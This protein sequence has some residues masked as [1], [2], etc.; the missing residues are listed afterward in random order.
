MGTKSNHLLVL[1]V[2]TGRIVEIT[3]P[4]APPRPPTPS[5]TESCGIHCMDVNPA[6]TMMATGGRNPNDC[7]LLDVPSMEPVATI[8]GHNDWLFGTAWV[9]DRH[10]VTGTHC[11]TEKKTMLG[12]TNTHNSVA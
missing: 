4:P 6:H 11:P 9:S 7:L 2:S 12:I 10:V 8:Q 3:L 5:H 1:H